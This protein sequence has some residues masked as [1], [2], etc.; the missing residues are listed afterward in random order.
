MKTKPTPAMP[1]AAS[2]I[3]RRDTRWPGPT[4]R[5]PPP[6]S[7]RIRPSLTHGAGLIPACILALAVAGPARAQT[8]GAPRWA[9][10]TLSTSVEGSILSSPAAGPDGTLHIGVQVGTA[11]SIAPSGRVFAVATSGAQKWM[12]LA[13]DW[14]DSTPAIGTD[15]AVYFG[16]WNG[17]LYALAADGAKRWEYQAGSF[18]TSSPAL[19]PDGTIYIGAGSDL[20]AVNADGTLKWLFPAGDWIDAS[21]AVGPDGTILFGSWDWELHALAPDGTE[22]WRFPTAGTITGSPA[23]AADGTCYIGSRDGYLYAVTREGTLKW[24]FNL[25]D[26]I[27]TSPA[28]GATGTIYVASSGGRLFA[29]NPDGTER[30]RYPRADQS[31]LLGLY[32]SPAVRAD[33]SIVLGTSNN[34]LI[35]VRSDGTQLWQAPLG[36]WSDSSPLVASD[37]NLYI[38]CA[39][40]KLYALTGTAAPLATD[41]PQFRRDGRR[42]G[43]QLFGSVPGTNGKMVNLSVRT[44]AGTEAGTLIVGF[45]VGGTGYR[46]LL[47]RGVG[48]TL[49]NFGV[50]GA[51]PD[52]RL[53]AYT[54]STVLATNNDWSAA[55]NAAAIASMAE[56]VGAF[57]L[58]AGSRDAALTG[59]FQPGGYTVQ[60]TDATGATGVALMEAYDAGGSTGGRLVNLSARGAVTNGSGVL[61]AGVVVTGSGRSVLVRGI[62]PALT[63]FGVPTTLARPR[64][65]IYQGAQVVAENE[66]WSTATN[67]AMIAATAAQVGAFALPPGSGDTALLLTLPPGPFTAQVSGIDASAGVALIEIYEVP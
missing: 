53:D 47:L 27:E 16:A 35:A 63:Q 45:V 36:D 9:F 29:L 44:I 39:D 61:I 23:L 33:G 12:F 22:K 64:L 18:I 50:S 28:L 60:V 48:P 57:P 52:P 24:S 40:K 55:A 34:A 51:L 10:T 30:W 8:D 37:G 38:G 7:Q 6:W 19:A 58:P 32:S 15:G 54:G 11:T 41:W 62:G 21:P 3:Q 5:R 43:W 59:D 66:N 4:G 25:G 56:S 26:P 49:N 42:S 65:R 2:G 20:V 67:A 46:T 14:V 31:S 17:V 13:P 1:P